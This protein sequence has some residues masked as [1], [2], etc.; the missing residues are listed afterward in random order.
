M[1]SIDI[2]CD[3]GEGFPDDARLMPFISSANIACGAHAGDL[4]LMRSTVELALQHGV[5]IGAHPG[6]EDRRNFGRV[7]QTLSVAEL[8][9]LITS[10]VHR[11]K[12]I[13]E[14]SG[15]CLQHVKPHGAL[16]NQS[17]RSPEIAAVI[18]EA[19]KDVDSRLYLYGLSG[20][21]SITAAREV[22][23][24]AREEV[25]ADRRYDDVGQLLPRS[26][27]EALIQDQQLACKQVLQMIKERSVTSFSGKV[28]PMVAET[29]CIHGDAEGAAE[30]ADYL[31]QY[32]NDHAIQLLQ[33]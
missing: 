27:P 30:L 24:A 33:K 20:S 4:L 25:F 11:L 7:E 32:L 23:L 2:N 17:A 9:D 31:Y 14:E 26:H 22:G 3:L 8:Y 13:T 10:Q 12:K 21:C 1:V 16:Y 19:V 18:A 28:I 5:G 15:G 29:I 6:Y